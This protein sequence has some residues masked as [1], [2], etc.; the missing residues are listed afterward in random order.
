M[1]A[2]KIL[3]IAAASVLACCGR[4]ANSQQCVGINNAVRAGYC[5]GQPYYYYFESGGQQYSESQGYQYCCGSPQN[6]TQ[7]VDY[8]LNAKLRAPGVLDELREVNRNGRML[9][10]SCT[11]N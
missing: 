7:L 2:G 9:V 4:R 5:C 6:V 3:I 11:G 10:A 8:C 1:K